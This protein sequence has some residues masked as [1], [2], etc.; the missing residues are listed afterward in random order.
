MTLT[1]LLVQKYHSFMRGVG[2]QKNHHLTFGECHYWPRGAEDKAKF[3]NVTKYG[4][5]LEGV[6]NRDKM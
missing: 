4:D 5:F 1:N 3:D 2:V 6:L